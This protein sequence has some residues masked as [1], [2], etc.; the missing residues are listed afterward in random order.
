MWSSKCLC[1]GQTLPG[2]G[3]LLLR[4]KAGLSDKKG[5]SGKPSLVPTTVYNYKPPLDEGLN[6][7][8]NGN[9]VS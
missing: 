2:K 8:I 1:L 5:L 3:P 7:Q 9:T 4:L 6:Q